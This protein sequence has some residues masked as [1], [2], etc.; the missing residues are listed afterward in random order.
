MTCQQ[1]LLYKTPIGVKGHGCSLFISSLKS[2]KNFWG[3]F[4]NEAIK[5]KH[6]DMV[7]NDNG[8]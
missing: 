4:F 7:L 5:I 8:A 2:I 1:Q 6:S 3:F